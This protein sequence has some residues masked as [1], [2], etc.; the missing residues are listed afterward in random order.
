MGCSPRRDLRIPIEDTFY[1]L[2]T[3]S[4]A[5]DAVRA[6]SWVSQDQHPEQ[7]GFMAALFYK[8][9]VIIATG[10]FDKERDLWMPV[11]DI[12]WHSA[13]TAY[14]CPTS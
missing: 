10:Q 11:A 3:D 8:D 13:A 7:R 5:D 2:A 14:E 12:S 6:L 4:T 9:F 1:I